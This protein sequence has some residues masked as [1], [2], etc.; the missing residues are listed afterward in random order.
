MVLP[1]A[2][3]NGKMAPRLSNKKKIKI[4]PI[5]MICIVGSRRNKDKTCKISCD[6]YLKLFRQN[7]KLILKIDKNGA[8]SST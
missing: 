1:Q 7:K 2:L 8:P 5:K 4:A 3:N 6:L